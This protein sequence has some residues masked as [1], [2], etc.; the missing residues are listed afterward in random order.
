MGCSV[1][2]R[3]LIFNPFHGPVVIFA[4]KTLLTDLFFLCQFIDCFR[5]FFKVIIVLCKHL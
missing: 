1:N 5:C 2:F 4:G 3:Y